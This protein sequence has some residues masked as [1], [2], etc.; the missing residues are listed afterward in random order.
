MT[1]VAPLDRFGPA[2]VA[3]AGGKG[4]GLG[5]LIAAGMPVPPGFV[6][7][8]DA[9]REVVGANGIQAA[10]LA[11]HETARVEDPVSLEA[12]AA[13]IA[14]LFASAVFSPELAADIES[15]YAALGLPGAPAAVAV[16]SSAT[17][18]DLED[19]SFAGQQETFLNVVGMA[20]LG[21]AIRRCWA[22]L[23]SGPAIAYRR[24]EG[25][26][27]AQ[28]AL[29]VVVQVLVPADSA[30]VLFTAD[31]VSG[32]RDH[33]VIDA[34]WGLGEA[35]VG[36]QV[37]PD[38]L[39]VDAGTGAWLREQVAD[40]QVMTVRD[41]QG[42]SLVPV[43][44]DL[45]R[46]PVLTT[47]QVGTLVEIARAIQAHTGRPTDVEWVSHDGH[48][49]VTQARAITALP[50]DLLGM[51]WSRQMLIERYPD[52]ITPLT[53]SAV[54]ST[55]FASLATTLRAL[56]GELPTHVPMIRLIH[57]RAYVNV[58]AFQQGM[59]S[60]PLRPPVA[61]SDPGDGGDGALGD[62]D[63]GRI[64]SRAPRTRPNEAMASAAL[65]LVRLV[66]GTHR[67]WERRLPDYVTRITAGASARWG[68]R[69]TAELLATRHTSAEAL[70]P[71]LDNHA[72]AIVA[73]DLTLQLLGG[74]TR[75][76]LGDE[77]QSLVLALLSGLTGN[78]TVETNRAL[79]QVA[80]FDPSSAQFEAGLASFLDRYGHRSPRYEFSHPTWREDPSQVREL[81]A[82]VAAGSPDPAVGE[83]QRRA[84]R[85]LATAQARSRLPLAKRMVFDRVVSLAQIYFRLRENQQFYLVLGVPTMRAILLEL[86]RRFAAEGWLPAEGD[87]F[88]LEN[89]EVDAL[90]ARLSGAEHL[91]PPAP[92]DP[93][94]LVETRRA[95]LDRHRRSSAPVHLGGTAEPVTVGD[96]GMKGIAASRGTATGRARLVRGPED[97]AA[98]RP[99]DILVAPATSPAWTPLFGVVAGLVTEFGGLLSHAG[100]VAREYGLPAVLGVPGVM[101]RISNGDLLTVEGHLGLV[102]VVVGQPTETAGDPAEGLIA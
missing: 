40:K 88:L 83:T 47:A 52:P 54:S 95:E 42:V 78:L 90:A 66:L 96:G 74:I 89:D 44:E 2:D 13:T 1:H 32:R 79:W 71:M 75:R 63:P 53:W 69:S 93:L 21:E 6:I 38:H 26:D 20:A 72:R 73:A 5:D 98:V 16:R 50:P 36:G 100:V 48:I 46:S 55:F 70:I 35:L 14:G 31:P 59:Q 68:E 19:A 3:I 15:G 67:D 41:E 25:I 102:T 51:E 11:A 62:G 30:G 86:G 28:V 49:L 80:Q 65:G 34:T 57:G 92:T 101:S 82:L 27:P 29:A 76:W 45:R 7:T 64:S 23:W 43:P 8:T 56:G 33:L 18:E 77:D 81:I 99:G 24:R 22:S 12:A 87:V 10:I 4:A 85:E 9:Y 60:L 97:F 91:G 37:I 84:A 39:V 17:A 58:T 94:R 61:P